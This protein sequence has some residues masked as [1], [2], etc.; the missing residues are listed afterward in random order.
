M[1]MKNYDESFE[2]NHNPNYSYIPDQP[3]QDFNHWLN[4]FR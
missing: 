2:P 4:G 3:Q 1:M